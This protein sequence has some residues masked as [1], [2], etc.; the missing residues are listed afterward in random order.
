[1]NLVLLG[2]TRTRLGVLKIGNAAK[3]FSNWLWTPAKFLGY[4]TSCCTVARAGLPSPVQPEGVVDL[5]HTP[6][7]L[8]R[9]ADL[10]SRVQLHREE[11]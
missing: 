6:A 5:T 11:C 8:T 4:S 2:I 10:T 3:R 1:M 9:L 7:D